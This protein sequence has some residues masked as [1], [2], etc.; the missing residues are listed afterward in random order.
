VAE[1]P[2]RGNRSRNC[3]LSGWM[4]SSICLV[5]MPPCSLMNLRQARSVK[6]R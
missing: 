4:L 1:G 2:C 3:T 5:H 6:R